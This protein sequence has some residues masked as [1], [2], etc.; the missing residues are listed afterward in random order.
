MRAGSASIRPRHHLIS[1]RLARMNE[2]PPET[3]FF[4]HLFRTES[5]A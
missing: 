5:R 3:S 4:P 1:A 2:P